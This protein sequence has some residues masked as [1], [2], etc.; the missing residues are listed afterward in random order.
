[1]NLA[2]MTALLAKTENEKI[3]VENEIL[4]YENLKSNGCHRILKYSVFKVENLSTF[5][6][7]KISFSLVGNSDETL[8]EIVEKELNDEVKMNIGQE[9]GKLLIKGFSI[10]TKVELFNTELQLSDIP[11]TELRT[12]LLNNL[13]CSELKPDI[14]IHLKIALD[15]IDDQIASKSKILQQL[16]QELTTLQQRVQSLAKSNGGTEKKNKKTI[17]RTKNGMNDKRSYE[18]SSNYFYTSMNSLSDIG[19]ITNAAVEYRSFILFGI[20]STAIYFFGDM[21]SV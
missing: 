21:A 17:K 19:I 12:E 15:K 7:L 6:D 11:D 13:Q 3:S 10:G 18:K 14:I 2:E 5:E 9:E 4:E 8:Q 20:A 1:M 16:E